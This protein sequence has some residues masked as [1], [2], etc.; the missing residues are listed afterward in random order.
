MH[1]ERSAEEGDYSLQRHQARF[2][3]ASPGV[4]CDQKLHAL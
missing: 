1:A 2:D 3:P 4:L